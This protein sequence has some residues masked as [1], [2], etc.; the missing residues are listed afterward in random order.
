MRETFFFER[1]LFQVDEGRLLLSQPCPAP[2]VF[3]EVAKVGSKQSTASTADTSDVM[4]T[5]LPIK[6]DECDP[7]TKDQLTC[8]SGWRGAL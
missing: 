1:R 2:Q 6:L 4:P 5:I 7:G 8:W 3:Q